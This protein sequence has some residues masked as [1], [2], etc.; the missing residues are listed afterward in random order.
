MFG[1]II[2]L[3]VLVI[4]ASLVFWIIQQIPLPEPIGKIVTIV[5]VVVVVLALVSMLLPLGGFG[6]WPLLYHH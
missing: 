5:L 3:L 2:S 4:L 1:L 6:S